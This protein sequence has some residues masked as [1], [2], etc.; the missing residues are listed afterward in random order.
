MQ[1]WR[2]P[3]KLP[4]T[5]KGQRRFTDAVYSFCETLISNTRVLEFKEIRKCTSRRG[6][7]IGCGS[8]TIPTQKPVENGIWPVKKRKEKEKGNSSPG[9]TLARGLQVTLVYNQNFPGRV[10]HPTRVN[11]T[12]LT[13]MFRLVRTKKR[14]S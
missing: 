6:R 10:I 5:I 3:P 2:V 11:F 7:E 14:S 12:S 8:D 13:D 9:V 4:E 1:P